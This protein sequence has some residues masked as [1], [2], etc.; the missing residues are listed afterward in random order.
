MLNRTA[1]GTPAAA[2]WSQLVFPNCNVFLVLNGHYPGEANRPIRTPAAARAPAALRLPEPGQRRRRLAALHDLQAGREQDLRLH[3]LADAGRRRRAVRDRHQQPV[4]ARLRHAGCA[5][6]ADRHH[7][8]R[9]LGQHDV[10]GWAGRAANTQYEWYATASDGQQT[11][12]GPTWTFTT[13]APANLPPTATPQ[14]VTTAEDVASGITLAGS[15]PENACADL[16]AGD[17]PGARRAQWRPHRP[18]PTRRRAN[19]AGP[20]SFTFTVNDGTQSS[21]PATVSLTI[22]PV[23]NPP[24]AVDGAAATSFGVPVDG[25][26]PPR[27][28]QP[29]AGVLHR[30]QRRQ[31]H[32]RR[33]GQRDGRLHLHAQHR[34]HR[35]D[36]RLD[37]S[38]HRPEQ[39][40][41]L[42]QP[43][44]GGNTAMA[45]PGPGRS[46]P[47]RSRSTT[48]PWTHLAT[49]AITIQDMGDPLVLR[50]VVG[51][52]RLHARPSTH[53]S[54]AGPVRGAVAFRFTAA[55]ASGRS[56]AGTVTIAVGR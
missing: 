5:V 32:G 49:F 51:S 38:Q 26:S 21:A 45:D 12:T 44:N 24:V 3:V 7:R 11:A 28:G 50:D 19:F 27:M 36:H 14:S 55:D 42:A 40:A 53:G 20:D 35:H 43:A 56:S 17:G 47:S 29:D 33:D 39:R 4:R 1:D 30:R 31:G 46:T 34:R 10:H 41:Q 13:A 8:R 54:P 23:N 18:S 15:D 2:V 9:G 37:C 22:T 25:T 48:S 52:G 6:C 16:R